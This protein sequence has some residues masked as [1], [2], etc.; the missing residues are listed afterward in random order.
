MPGS[1]IWKPCTSYRDTTLYSKYGYY[2]YQAFVMGDWQD[3]PPSWGARNFGRLWRIHSYATT[4]Y[5]VL[6]DLRYGYDPVGNVTRI[7]DVKNDED[8][9]FT[10]DTL[11]RL[12][13]TSGAYTTTYSYD[14]IGNITSFEGQVYTYTARP[15]AVEQAGSNS[16]GY[17][18]NGNMITR[19][20]GSDTYE[21][22][23][24]AENRLTE[25][26]RNGSLVATFVYDGNGNRVKAI[27]NGPTTVYIG[28]YYEQTESTTERYHYAAGRQ[29]AT[30]ESSTFS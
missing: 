17:D 7:N 1:R 24:D 4:P 8:V 14:A 21:L 2:G 19:T 3:A 26:E 27:V 5:T 25:V 28:D 11:D 12:I 13:G 23:Y 15:H 9:S 18:D 30:R 10:Y 6:Q 29:V 20:V 16:Y 22:T